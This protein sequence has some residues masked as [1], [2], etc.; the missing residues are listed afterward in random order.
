[1]RGKCA[2]SKLIDI[3]LESFILMIDRLGPVHMLGV[4]PRSQVWQ[5]Q[6]ASLEQIRMNTE[7]KITYLTM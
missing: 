3:A 5:Q 6:T 2:D 4:T 1:M 7:H